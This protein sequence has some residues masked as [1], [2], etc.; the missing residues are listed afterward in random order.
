MRITQV[1]ITL[2]LAF[3]LTFTVSSE[4][5]A[6]DPQFTQ[7]YANPLYLNP[8]FAGT[9]R[10]PRLVMAYRNQWPSLSDLMSL[11]APVMTSMSLQLVVD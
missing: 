4:A 6:Q 3:V 5:Q 10:C 9:A 7:F 8:A 11:L 2:G 1:L